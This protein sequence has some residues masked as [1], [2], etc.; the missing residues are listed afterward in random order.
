MALDTVADV[1]TS[2]PQTVEADRPAMEAARLMRDHDFGDVPVTEGGRLVGIVTDR[3]I[4]VRLVA[5]GRDPGTA[6]R[7]VCTSG[8]LVTVTADTTATEAVRLMREHAVRR[9]PVLD[10]DRLIGI[11]SLGDMAIEHD[12]TSALADISAAPPDA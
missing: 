8:S 1:M 4:A 10:G 3:D 11:V 5:E 2:D 12:E 6:V 7:E 9:L